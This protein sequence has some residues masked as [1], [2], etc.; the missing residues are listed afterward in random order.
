[1][2]SELI[3][4]NSKTLAKEVQVVDCS[5]RRSGRLIARGK[6]KVTQFFQQESS[7]S[8]GCNSCSS[9]HFKKTSFLA[10]Y[11]IHEA[12]SYMVDNVI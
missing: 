2:D 7:G 5:L 10:L 6:E 12:P 4:L 11:E 8:G 9:G 1:M 3:T